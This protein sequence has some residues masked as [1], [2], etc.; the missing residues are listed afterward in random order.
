MK[1]EW[2]GKALSDLDRLYEFLVP[3]N[4]KA[5]AIAVQLLV[6]ASKH[7]LEHP[8]IGEQL[9]EFNPREVRRIIVNRYEIRYEIKG[10]TLYLLRL[11]HTKE[12]R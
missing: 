3:S 10:Q 2:S 12:E 11:W 5:A 6:R 8:R 4:K 9:E 7:L 1:I